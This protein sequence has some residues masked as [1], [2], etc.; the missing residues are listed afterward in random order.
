MTDIMMP[1]DEAIEGDEP[2][3]ASEDQ[4][5]IDRLTMF[6]QSGDIAGVLS[7]EE[8]GKE[9]LASIGAAAIRHFKL[10]EDSRSEWVDKSKEAMKLARQVADE[11]TYPWANPSNILYPLISE[12]AIQFN[13]RS[14]PA[15]VNGKNIVKAKINGYDGDGSKQVQGDRVAMHMSWQLS[16]ESPEWEDDTDRLLIML[17]I[18]GSVFRKWWF[19]P[20][21]G[22]NRSEVISAEDFVVNQGCKSL[23]RTPRCSFKFTRYPYEIDEKQRSGEWLDVEIDENSG[24]DEDAPIQFIEHYTRIDLD[25]DGYA[26]PYAV[27]IHVNTQQ[28]LRIEPCFRP[29]KVRLKEGKI[30]SIEAETYFA[31][32]QFMPDPDGGFYGLGFGQL[33][34]GTNKAINGV[35]NML[36]DAG[37]MST[38]GGGFLGKGASIQGGSLQFKPGEWKKVDTLGGVLAQNIVPLP[39]KEPSQVMFSLL[40]MLIES[41]KSLA[42]TKDILTGENTN[43]QM[44][45]TLGL[46]L[47][48]QGLKVFS[49]IYKRVHRALHDELKILY[50]LNQLY[51]N[52]QTYFTFLDTKDQIGPEDYSSDDL[53]VVPVTDP[54]VVT[55]M[56]RLGRAQ[57]LMQF[58]GNPAMNSQEIINRVL[59]AAGIEDVKKLF[60]EQP[61]VDPKVKEAE[62]KANHEAMRIQIDGR[63]AMADILVKET[64]AI[65]N[66]ADAE[67]VEVGS[68]L[69]FYQAQFNALKEQATQDMSNGQGDTG[70]GAGVAEGPDNGSGLAV[71]SGLRPEPSGTVDAGGGNQLA[72]AI[73]GGGI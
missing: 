44:P 39:T 51:T 5:G 38:L 24:S 4:D 59:E 8:G 12:A 45:A 36:M 72:G 71:P 49:A 32:Y 14:Y 37:H 47:I 60:A 13:A 34:Y 1:E 63:R 67:A 25:E 31:H 69:G 46:A 27:T 55:D 30:I 7:E 19:D 57:F 33:L 28:V 16:E 2:I 41:G 29:E 9:R 56:Q 53:N 43:A 52:P 21:L 22:R 50:R 18:A 73:Q 64:Q 70:A 68:Q 48:E 15:I 6:L 11:K 20:D 61:P 35:I 17:P 65:K 42:A 3:D 26:E 58:V 62:T 66:I 40:G 23:S 10:D 54:S